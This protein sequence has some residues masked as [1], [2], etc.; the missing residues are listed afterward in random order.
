MKLGSGV[1][2]S[3]STTIFL[4]VLS[5]LIAGIGLMFDNSPYRYGQF[6]SG[7]LLVQ[8]G[9]T[10]VFL[11][12]G[13]FGMVTCNVTELTSQRFQMRVAWTAFIVVAGFFVGSLLIAL[14]YLS[15]D[16]KKPIWTDW[17]VVAVG[18]ISIVLATFSYI[19]ACRYFFRLHRLRK[20]Y[21]DLMG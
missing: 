2:K 12:S 14:H 20:P 16:I 21:R 5:F 3:F 11:Y 18:M 15:M 7:M 17:L 13:A 19:Q 1:I 9:C 6:G 8:F 4:G 10:V